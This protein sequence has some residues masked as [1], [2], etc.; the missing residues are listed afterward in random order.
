MRFGFPFGWGQPSIFNRKPFT[1]LWFIDCT[2][3]PQLERLTNTHRTLREAIEKAEVALGGHSQWKSHHDRT[4][5]SKSLLGSNQDQVREGL[6]ES[7]YGFLCAR[8]NVA[9]TFYPLLNAT[10]A[11][12][13]L[14]KEFLDNKTEKAIDEAVRMGNRDD[15]TKPRLHEFHQDLYRVNM[16][17]CTT[18]LERVYALLARPEFES[19]CQIKDEIPVSFKELIGERKIISAL[20]AL[21]YP[22]YW[23]STFKG[24]LTWF[25][26]LMAGKTKM[27]WGA[28]NCSGG[29]PEATSLT[30]SKAGW[31]VERVEAPNGTTGDEYRESTYYVLTPPSPDSPK[32]TD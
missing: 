1:H 10:T 15:K 2:D 13:A 29:F 3:I 28:N 9:A 21:P 11:M 24:V 31:N 32:K 20:P 27:P 30:F 23:G 6:E 12:Q 18:L 14:L 7:H 22:T 5:N 19:C 26:E 25:G 8:L 4:L 16:H 17:Y